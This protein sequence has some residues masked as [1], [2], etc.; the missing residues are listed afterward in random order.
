MGF[1]TS[2]ALLD[3]GTDKNGFGY[4]GTG[5]KSTNKQFDNYGQSFTL[6]DTVGCLID[7]DEG[8]ISFS[9]N[10]K[11]FPKAFVIPQHC[12]NKPLFPAVV[13]KNAEIRFNFG[14][15][16]FQSLPK[17]SSFVSF[18]LFRIS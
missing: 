2:D 5:K 15:Q 18:V 8:Y 17:V 3:L 11:I 4:G 12:L 9:K 7:F 6:G 13:L 16:P 14:D 10:G 1:S